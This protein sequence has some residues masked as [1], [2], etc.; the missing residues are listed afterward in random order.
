[1]EPKHHCAPLPSQ[2]GGLCRAGE[3]VLTETHFT[4]GSMSPEPSLWWFPQSGIHTWNMPSGRVGS[5][6][7]WVTCILKEMGSLFLCCGV[8]N[9]ASSWAQG[10]DGRS[11]GRVDPASPGATQRKEE[12]WLAPPSRL[13]SA[14]TQVA[15]TRPLTP[16]VFAPAVP[17]SGQG[18]EF[19]L[20]SPGHL[21]FLSLTA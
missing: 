17:N 7:G 4:V 6:W 2:N 11:Q 5:G 10:I 20:C 1:M 19:C 21:L 8:C 18:W 3:C 16:R 15:I 12:P 13:P 14:R 9:A